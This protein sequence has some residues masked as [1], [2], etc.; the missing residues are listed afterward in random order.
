MHA[1]A[2]RVHRQGGFA[3]LRQNGLLPV[4]EP[5]HRV[6][7]PSDIQRAPVLTVPGSARGQLPFLGFSDRRNVRGDRYRA[8]RGFGQPRA[9]PGQPI[10]LS[11]CRLSC[12]VPG[13]ASRAW[14]R[15]NNRTI[16]SRCCCSHWASG[17]KSGASWSSAS[18]F[19]MSG[20]AKR[21]RF[22]REARRALTRGVVTGLQEPG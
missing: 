18:T 6:S 19:A 11:P 4:N 2:L 16:V 15:S 9:L 3:G 1:P 8:Q 13:R 17:I 5:T 22:R 12:S 14:F 20:N 21:F 7:L 10:R